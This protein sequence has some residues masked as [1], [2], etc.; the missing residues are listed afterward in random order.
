MK[1]EEDLFHKYNWEILDR[2]KR[3][4]CL[5]ELE[6]EEIVTRLGRSIINI[7]VIRPWTW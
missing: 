3:V 7:V 4:A 2:V 1:V 6:P 5:N